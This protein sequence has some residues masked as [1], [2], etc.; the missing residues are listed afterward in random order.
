MPHPKTI[1]KYVLQVTD[2][3]VFMMPK[4]AEILSVAN[5]GGQLCLW[6]EVDPNAEYEER[7]FDIIGT[8]NPM[9]SDMGVS[10]L[11]IGT[12][13]MPPFVWHVYERFGF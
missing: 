11:F 3:Q 9:Y 8:G 2:H 12:V 6:A 1:W 7:T 5:Q 10:R 4:G 13:L